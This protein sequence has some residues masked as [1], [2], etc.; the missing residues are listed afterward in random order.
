MTTPAHSDSAP[1]IT[2]PTEGAL[3]TVGHIAGVRG[4]QGQLKI[5]SEETPPT[6]L[7]RVTRLKLTTPSQQQWFTV[8]SLA[9]HDPLVWAFLEGITTP[10]QGALWRSATV[11][12]AESD[13]PALPADTYRPRDLLHK[14]VWD[15]PTQAEVG[16]VTGVLFNHDEPFL[17]ITLTATQ[18][19][20]MVPFIRAFFGEVEPQKLWALLDLHT[21]TD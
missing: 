8:K 20:C 13:L 15:Q 12:A 9:W 17:E 6:W 1:L 7:T 5:K 19:T 2:T 18:K 21:L 4:V 3:L 11:E 14:P 16:Q 10:E